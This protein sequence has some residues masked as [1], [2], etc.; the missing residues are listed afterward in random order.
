MDDRD[1][2]KI[3]QV[4]REEVRMAIRDLHLQTYSPGFHLVGAPIFEP[5][6][7]DDGWVNEKVE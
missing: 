3:R 4:I 1:L 2:R 5:P 6:S 7:L